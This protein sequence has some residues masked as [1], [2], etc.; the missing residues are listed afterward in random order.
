MN[1]NAKQTEP[2]NDV[3]QSGIRGVQPVTTVKSQ[4]VHADGTIPDLVG[5]DEYGKERVLI[6]VKFWAELTRHQPVAYLERLPDDGPVVVMFLIPEDRVQSLWPQLKERLSRQFDH[7]T[8]VD[9]ERKC[10]RV[11]DTEKHLMMASWGGL[12]DTMAARSTDFDEAGVHTEIRQLRTL[13]RYADA[14][15]F[16]PISP[17]EELGK[18]SEARLRQYKRLIDAATERGIE[19]EWIS[20]KGLNRTPRRY[21]YGRYIRLLG[22]IVWFGVNVDQFEKTRITPLWIGCSISPDKLGVWRDKLQMNDDGWIPVDLK[23]DVKY[24]EILDGVVDSLKHIAEV[25][26]GL[27]VEYR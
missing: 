22:Y 2:L 26:H 19:Q 7:L 20:K 15:A 13:A 16:K 5:F 1:P 17:G 9:S 14:G 25:I 10:L 24:P 6:E 3:V 11:R 21:G 23:K 18:D 4:V 27:P 8:E 12:L